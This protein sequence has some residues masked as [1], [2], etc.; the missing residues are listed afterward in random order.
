MKYIGIGMIW[1]GYALAVSGVAFGVQAA[2]AAVVVGV[3]GATCAAYATHVVA[4][5]K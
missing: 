2:D 3:A 4:N 1:I 5:S